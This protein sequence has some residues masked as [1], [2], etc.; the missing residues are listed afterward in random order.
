MKKYLS[1]LII[2]TVLTK[3]SAQEE[4]L[5]TDETVT[6]YEGTS[7]LVVEKLSIK[8]QAGEQFRV[9]ASEHGPFH[10]KMYN[11]NNNVNGSLNKNYVRIETSNVQGL[12]NEYSFADGD[13][14]KKSISFEYINGLNQKEQINNVQSSPLMKDLVELMVFD[15]MGN[16][17]KSYLPYKS[18]SNNGSYRSSAGSEVSSYYTSLKSDNRPF[19][20]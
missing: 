10:I 12:T 5:V 13:I 2:M 4:R 20:E 15:N 1:I 18:G 11:K 3:V 16:V 6:E 7:Y 8:P 19:T 17:K 9:S 14:E